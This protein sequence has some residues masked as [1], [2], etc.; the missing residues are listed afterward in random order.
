MYKIVF[1]ED[2]HGKSEV[3]DYVTGIS[4]SNQKNDVAVYKKLVHQMN[5][6]EM[7]GFALNEPQVKWLSGLKY[8]LWELRPM[9]ERFFYGAWR[10]NAFVILSHYTK[11][12]DRTDPRELMKALSLLEDWYERNGR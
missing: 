11:K 7:M 3:S 8:P 2:E 10:D 1:Y 6:L 9:P 4:Q 5:M 12:Q